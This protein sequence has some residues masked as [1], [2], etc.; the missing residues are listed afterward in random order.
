MGLERHFSERFVNE[1]TPT[2][3]LICP[4]YH[5]GF[6]LEFHAL[7][8]SENRKG[9]SQIYPKIEDFAQS[10]ITWLN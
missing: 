1:I 3:P 6:F 5:P 10:I 2:N 8:F 7:C 9:V 4:R